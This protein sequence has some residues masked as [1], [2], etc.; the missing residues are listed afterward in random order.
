MLAS[1]ERK[2]PYFQLQFLEHRCMGP[3]DVP[4]LSLNTSFFD[5]SVRW[6]IGLLNTKNRYHSVG[7]MRCASSGWMKEEKV[8]SGM[9]Y[10]CSTP[11]VAASPSPNSTFVH[12]GADTATLAASTTQ[13]HQSSRHS[14]WKKLSPIIS[15]LLM[16]KTSRHSFATDCTQP[17]ASSTPSPQIGSSYR[18]ATHL[19]TTNPAVHG[20]LGYRASLSSYPKPDTTKYFLALKDR[21]NTV[22]DR[23]KETTGSLA[24]VV[25]IENAKLAQSEARR[26]PADSLKFSMKLRDTTHESL[27][28]KIS[29]DAHLDHSCLLPVSILITAAWVVVAYWPTISTNLVQCVQSR[30]PRIDLEMGDL[31]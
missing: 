7:L 23:S 20:G 30:Q 8:L 31:P 19:V 13:Q 17:N 21:M 15:L 28:G 9:E 25:S 29:H 14:P 10:S 24:A 2:S 12:A 6:R 27:I 3:E 18:P 22:L 16:Q 5:F 1:D 11:Q 4:Q 26:E